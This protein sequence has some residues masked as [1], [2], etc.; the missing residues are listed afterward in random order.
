MNK[1]NMLFSLF[2]FDDESGI[3]RYSEKILRLKV[4][5]V[6]AF[7]LLAIPIIIILFFSLNQLKKS[8]NA[9]FLRQTEKVSS[10]INERLFKRNTLANLIATNEFAYFMYTFDPITKQVTKTLSPLTNL[11]YYNRADGVVGYFLLPESGEIRSP[12]LPYSLD[13]KDKMVD[14]ALSDLAVRQKT[15]LKIE[16][17]VLQSIELK[18]IFK[19][20]NTKRKNQFQLISDVPEY[21]IFYRVVNNETQKAIQ[22][23]VIDRKKYLNTRIV[24]VLNTSSLKQDVSLTIFTPAPAK[25]IQSFAFKHAEK[26]NG[27]FE[28]LE[29]PLMEDV[30]QTA[31]NTLDWPFDNYSIVYKHH[32]LSMSP[33][34]IYTITFISLLLIL[35]AVSCLIFYRIG[36]KELQLSEQRLNFVSSVSH[37]LR[38]PL[39]SILMYIDML[40]SNT[41]LTADHR[42]E[43]YDFIESESERLSRLIDNMLRLATNNTNNEVNLEYVTLS[44]IIDILYTKLSPLVNK[45]HFQL[46]VSHHFSKSEKINILIDIDSFSQIALNICENSIKFFTQEGSTSKKQIDFTFSQSNSD[47]NEIM[48]EIRDYGKGIQATQLPYIFEPFYR[49]ENE[50]TRTTQGSGLGLAIVKDLVVAQHGTISAKNVSPGL[51]ISIN[52]KHKDGC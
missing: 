10:A 17:V 34:A 24:N 51:A 31:S 2:K 46:N 29:K 32:A 11:D 28:L 27:S 39:T 21:F 3:K 6:S 9:E 15:A 33:T 35:V 7:I 43:Y 4:L 44:E 13:S 20:I 30:E 52:F 42:V 50:L 1:V 26:G 12:L 40:K 37:E 36:K 41:L 5:V 38:T 47:H 45:H 14:V 16:K 18:Q 25:S 19:N 48:L 8:Q 23:Y 49:G 22:G